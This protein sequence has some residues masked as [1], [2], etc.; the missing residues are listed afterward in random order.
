MHAVHKAV[1]NVRRLVV[2]HILRTGCAHVLA[3]QQLPVHSLV[4][5]SD[6]FVQ[7]EDKCSNFFLKCWWFTNCGPE[8]NKKAPRSHQEDGKA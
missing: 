2:Q 4:I 3:A 8:L 5:E 7:E 6:A 1:Q